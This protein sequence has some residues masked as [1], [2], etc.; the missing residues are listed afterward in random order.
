VVDWNKNRLRLA[1]GAAAFAGDATADWPLGIGQ[2]SLVFAFL[3]KVGVRGCRRPYGTRCLHGGT[4]ANSH[5]F[6][7]DK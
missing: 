1:P 7:R 6:C 3:K 2:K 5:N 4:A